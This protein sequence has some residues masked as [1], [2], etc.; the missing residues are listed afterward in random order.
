MKKIL[1]FLSLI[2]VLAGPAIALAQPIQ[3]TSPD[4]D[5]EHDLG[6]YSACC[7]TITRERDAGD[8][9]GP[10]T[11]TEEVCMEEGDNTADWMDEYEEDFAPC[12]LI[13]KVLTVG[14]YIFVAILVVAILIILL[15]GWTFLTAAGSPDKVGKARNYL[16]YGIIGIAVAFLA[17]VLVKVVAAIMA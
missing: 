4:C 13:D 1:I 7:V 3:T 8:P 16:I 11:V 2:T 14:D 6:S 12:C 17:R 5:V 9:P 15:A 10:P